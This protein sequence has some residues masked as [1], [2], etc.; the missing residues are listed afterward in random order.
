MIPWDDY[1]KKQLK[2]IGLFFTQERYRQ[3]KT[4]RQVS[5]EFGAGQ[6]GVS[7]FEKGLNDF[8]FSTLQKL[9]RTL[10]YRVEL[11]LIPMDRDPVKGSILAK[12]DLNAQ[13]T[14]EYGGNT[15]KLS[16]PRRIR[17]PVKHKPIEQAPDVDY[18][19]ED[20]FDTEK[21]VA[22]LRARLMG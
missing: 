21:E 20:E 10:G 19:F 12:P 18:E 15:F 9:A 14:R 5:E 6:A 7:I 17:R 1:E 3:K 2:D 4:Q 13:S 11:R 8:R 16:G 22:A